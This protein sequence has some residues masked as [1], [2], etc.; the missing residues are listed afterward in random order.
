MRSDLLASLRL[1]GLTIVV[2]S[3]AYPL[4]VLAI[5]VVIAPDARMGSLVA[6][7]EGKVVGSRLVAQSFSRPE[8]FWP[9][10]SAV[11]Y[12]AAGAGGSNLSP[13][14]P[15]IRQRAEETIARLALS[16]EMPA[17]ADLVTA[18]G[19]GLDPHI[20]YEGAIAQ[21]PRVATSRGVDENVVVKMINETAEQIPLTGP[22]SR[23]VNVLELNLALDTRNKR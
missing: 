14:N 2:C 17:P 18:S 8:Y 6:N 19:G 20:S 1:G 10:P 15:A 13:A 4:T 9:R 3:V 12:N 7:A 23:I 21:A 22:S 16:A 11:D 5:A